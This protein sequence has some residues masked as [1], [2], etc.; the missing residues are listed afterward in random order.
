MLLDR[1]NLITAWDQYQGFNDSPG[2]GGR[3]TGRS[4]LQLV[5]R[6]LNDTNLIPPF[7]SLVKQEQALY[8]QFDATPIYLNYFEYDRV[9]QTAFVDSTLLLDA[10]GNF[11]SNPN[12]SNNFLEKKRYFAVGSGGHLNNLAYGDT[13]PFV[14]PSSL[15]FSNLDDSIVSLEV[16]FGDDLGFRSINFDEVVKVFYSTAGDT[17]LWSVKINTQNSGILY[18]KM[19]VSTTLSCNDMPFPVTG[20]WGSTL[21]NGKS[22]QYLLPPQHISAWNSIKGLGNAYVCT[23]LI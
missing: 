4:L 13:L 9:Y 17:I 19:M 1:V 7:D 10:L 20:P 3:Q 22:F 11:I 12:G 18:T 14:F 16:D 2:V 21:I 5:A 23:D 6:A 15:F 8:E